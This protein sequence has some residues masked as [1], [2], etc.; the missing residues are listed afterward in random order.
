MKKVVSYLVLAIF[1][2]F[3][4][5]GI[6]TEQ[7]KGATGEWPPYISQH[8]KNNGVIIDIVDQVMAGAGYDVSWEFFPW[9]RAYKNTV[10]GLADISAVWSYSKERSEELYISDI[11]FTSSTVL[12]HRKDLE[13]S[14][15]QVSDLSKYRLGGAVGY[16]YGE[17]LQQAED[18]GVIT[19]E[20]IADDQFNLRKL[21]SGRID[22]AILN[23]DVGYY[24]IH[25]MF[26][27]QVVATITNHPRKIVNSE[28]RL[29]ISKQSSSGQQILERFNQSLDKNKE[30][31]T[32][33]LD[34]SRQ[35][36]Y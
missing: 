28:L 4:T 26:P 16:Y 7:V 33:L 18:D 27:P 24:M 2:L 30:L 23:I 1:W 8:I 34:L 11:I 13:V 6:A 21:V 20:R 5:Q 17:A 31:V 36:L 15:N 14:W 32:E 25:D 19:I 3:S 10:A 12:F 9:K 22:I 35:G 29:L